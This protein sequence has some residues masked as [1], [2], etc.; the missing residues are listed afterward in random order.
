MI[1]QTS[2]ASISDDAI[3]PE[4]PMKKKPSSSDKLQSTS[5]PSFTSWA[6]RKQESF[7]V[8]CTLL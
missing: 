1:K 7:D 3:R 2:T 6:T 8:G 4:S 5:T